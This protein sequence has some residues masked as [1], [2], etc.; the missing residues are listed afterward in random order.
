MN[1]QGREPLLHERLANTNCC[2]PRHWDGINAP[3]QIDVVKRSVLSWSE[4]S[5]GPNIDV[6]LV[7]LET[8][9][10]DPTAV[11]TW[12]ADT[13][14]ATS[15]PLPTVSGRGPRASGKGTDGGGAQGTSCHW[16]FG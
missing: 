9:S 16:G 14:A 2:Q 10:K 8:L 6:A 5:S 1:A 15:K 7:T 12:P 11:E 4:K 3:L 13:P